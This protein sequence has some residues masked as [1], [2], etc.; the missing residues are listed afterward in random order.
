MSNLVR[1]MVKVDL[2][3]HSA[4]SFDNGMATLL[5]TIIIKSFDSIA[6]VTGNSKMSVISYY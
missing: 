3:I 1:E 4:A 2:H 5:W 6:L